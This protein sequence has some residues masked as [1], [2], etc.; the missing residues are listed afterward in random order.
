MR[1]SGRLLGSC[2]TCRLRKCL[3]PLD[4]FAL[5]DPSELTSAITTSK[6]SVSPGVRPN[7]IT[8]G[9]LALEWQFHFRQVLQQQVVL[10][11]LH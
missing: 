10:L 8:G 5:T 11:K 4:H 9:Y 3:K 6:P 1:L 7:A 2:Q